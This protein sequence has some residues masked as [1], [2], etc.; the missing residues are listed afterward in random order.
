LATTAFQTTGSVMNVVGLIPVV[1]TVASVANI[2]TDVSARL[3]EAQAKKRRWYLL[4]P[5]MSEV[6]LTNILR[7]R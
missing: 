4:G 5:K 7:R 2:A 6:A 3:A 1:G